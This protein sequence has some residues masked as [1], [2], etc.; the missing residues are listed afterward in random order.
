[1][2]YPADPDELH[3]M[4][5][6]FLDHAEASSLLPPKAVIVPHAGYV[7]SGAVAASAYACVDPTEISRVVLIG[8]SHR[9][10]LEGMAIPESLIW[11]TPIGDVQIDFDAMEKVS[12]FAQVLFSERAHLEEHCL[13]VQLPFLQ[14]LL[15]DRF[16]LAP[17]VVG[18]CSPDDVAD[19][20]EVLWGGPETLV[21]VS[22]DLSHYLPYER[23]CL[24][25]QTTVR[26]IEDLDVYRL[27]GDSA[28]G[29][30][31]IAGLICLAQRRGMRSKLLDLR[32]SGDTAGSREQVVGY[33]AF[34]FY[35]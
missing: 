3:R 2:F 34:A 32:N 12:S 21:V 19:V 6:R 10:M 29:L 27:E 33:G 23:A 18:D 5:R 25:D 17:M 11:E 9:V 26:A 20:L 30:N 31:A 28:C 35:E 8:P 7:Y 22:S 1:M 14:E 24:K 13:E 15:G 16:R 4:V